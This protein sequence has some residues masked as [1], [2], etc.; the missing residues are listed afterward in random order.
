MLFCSVAVGNKKWK[1]KKQKTDRLTQSALAAIKSR[2]ILS[3]AHQLVFTY[4]RPLFNPHRIVTQ[5][6]LCCLRR[7]IPQLNELLI[8]AHLGRFIS[9]K[10]THI[11]S[12]S[13]HW[14][15]N[16]SNPLHLHNNWCTQWPP[17]SNSNHQIFWTR[18]FWTRNFQYFCA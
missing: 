12:N 3:A 1:K 17:T 15:L 6:C 16:I 9:L 4:P 8:I 2:L 13:F 10:L 11:S 14:L 5:S 7:H 18:N